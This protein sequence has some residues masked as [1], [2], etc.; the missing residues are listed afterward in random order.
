MA[1]RAAPCLAA[2]WNFCLVSGGWGVIV[3]V[4][5]WGDA[6]GCRAGSFCAACGSCAGVSKRLFFIQKKSFCGR[7]SPNKVVY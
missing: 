6:V 2:G 7:K 3:R 1:G 5:R 4:G